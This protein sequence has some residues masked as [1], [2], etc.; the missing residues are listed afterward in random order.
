MVEHL[1]CFIEYQHLNR[2]S[3]EC[4]SLDH[5]KNPARGPAHNMNAVVQFDHVIINISATNAAMNRD[6]HVIPERLYNFL[7][8]FSQLPG[9]REH[10][11][12]WLSDGKVHCLQTPEREDA[13]LTSA[14][15]CLDDHVPPLQD[16]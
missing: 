2:L 11:D 7:G 1:V 15:L 3:F 16:R 8:L 9:R 6:A 10:Q 12:L 13:C 14:A 5:I 4:F